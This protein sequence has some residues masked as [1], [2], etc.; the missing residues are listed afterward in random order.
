MAYKLTSDD[1]HEASRAVRADGE[2][3][4][5]RW[6]FSLHGESFHVIDRDVIDVDL[7]TVR[8]DKKGQPAKRSQ[9]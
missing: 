1:K 7:E 5:N 9:R 3:M 4:G 2:P 6:Y 8:I